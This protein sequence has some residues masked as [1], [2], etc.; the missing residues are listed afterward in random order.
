MP[1]ST[2]PAQALQDAQAESIAKKTVLW[3]A[4]YDSVFVLLQEGSPGTA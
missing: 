1:G 2:A 3:D 4:H